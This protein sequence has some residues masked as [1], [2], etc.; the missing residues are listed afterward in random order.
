[1]D[2]SSNITLQYK[3]AGLFSDNR[4]E[5]INK[6]D[7]DSLKEKPVIVALNSLLLDSDPGVKEAA[8]AK[9]KEVYPQA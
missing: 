1:M 4:R 5:A 6:L 9:L 7:T 3:I 8:Q 2:I